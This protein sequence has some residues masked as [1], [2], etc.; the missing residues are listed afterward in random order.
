MPTYTNIQATDADE[1]VSVAGAAAT[2]TLPAYFTVTG[3]R[4]N[5]G[6]A[7]IT[8]NSGGPILYTTNGTAPTDSTDTTGE[9]L[10]VGDTLIVTTLQEM[11]DL[12]MI[13]ATGATATVFVRYEART[14]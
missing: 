3:G 5:H 10:E 9:R 11:K 12:N 8:V 4:V 2:L 7:V 14:S 13:R 1:P 6:R